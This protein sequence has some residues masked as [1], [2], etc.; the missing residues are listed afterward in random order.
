MDVA[1]PG[2]TPSSTPSSS[3]VS[4]SSSRLKELHER[5]QL[6]SRESPARAD[7]PPTWREQPV[8]SV[9]IASYKKNTEGRYHR[10]NRM[11][12]NAAQRA[13][14]DCFHD[15]SWAEY[16]T[17]PR[18]PEGAA[19]L[20]VGDSLIR[21][22]TRI[23]SHWQTGVLSF[24]GAATPQMLASLEM[25]GLAKM[26][27]VTLMMGT[28]DVSRGELR[29]VIGLHDKMSC[30]LEE[31]RIQMDP[32]ILT[33]CTVPYN[34]MADQH[35]MEM[36]EKGR[37]LNEIIKQIHQRSVLP[38]RLLDV[39]DQMEQS[40]PEDASSDGIYFDRPRGV[41]W[42]N[43]VFQRHI[44][45]LEANLLE[46]DRLTFGPPPNPPF[47]ATRPLSSRLGA[48]VNSRDSSRSS[49]T[50]LP[51][52]TPMEAEEA[53]SSTPQS[54]VVSSVVVVEDKRVEKTAE[55]SRTRSL[56]KV[57]ELDLE[58]LECR[59]ELAEVLGLKHVS[60]EDLSRHQ[61]VDWLK[62]HK[63]HFSR[64]RMM[65]TADLTGITMRSVMGPINYIPLKLLGSPGPIVEP[66]KHRTSIARIRLA[67]PAQLRVVD[68][69]LDP[70]EME[71]P[72]AAYEGAKLADD[73]RYG[74]T[75]GNA[76]LA[77]TLAVY[78]RADPA[79]ARVIIVT[80]SDFK[81]T[82]P[83]L[84]WPET[85]V[86]LLPGAE[87]NQMLTLVVAIKSEMPCEPELLLFA[88]MNDHLHAA[89]LLEQLKGV[90]HTPK[91][92]WEAIQT[93]FAAMNEV[94]ENVSSQFGSKT[95]VVFTT[96]PGYASM[97]PALQFV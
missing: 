48:G 24:S 49:R 29:K 15:A 21:V 87:L 54:S 39:A 45:E 4:G 95:K 40:F 56:E 34:M 72:D 57:K 11:D 2:Y 55:A 75:C 62:A 58:D 70:R 26:Y 94:Q 47:L 22:L 67:T 93:L 79:A 10:H 50:R 19:H 18:I 14:R 51:G 61:C 23:Q 71:L 27:T 20:I 74:K 38:I 91:K 16:F 36:N 13:R 46:T 43:D 32:A 96:T 8:R 7:V 92:I 97:P 25:V 90:E 37:A 78:D 6:R 84:F 73:P 44:N 42:L 33:V 65:K 35:A 64:A 31:L 66:A 88:G 28:N 30:I 63:A 82:S 41:E 83:K 81:G 89:G 77:K 80:A 3:Q 69:L 53:A 85:L 1:L 5:L 59:Q 9:V 60:H 68:K 76:Q 17:Q 86:H 12:W 52:S